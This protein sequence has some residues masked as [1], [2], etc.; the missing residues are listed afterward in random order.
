[1]I[2]MV[3]KVR[4]TL[5]LREG[6]LDIPPQKCITRD[7]APLSA[8]AVVYWK[9]FD[10]ELA[11]YAVADLVPAIQNLVLT[12][13]R[14]EIGKL[15]LDE[16]FSAREGINRALL[17]E[18]DVSTDAWGVKIT[19]VEVR[20]IIPNKEILSAMELQMAAER[21]KRADISKS[22]GQQLSAVNE[23]QGAADAARLTAEAAKVSV[24]LAAEAEKAR[25]TAEAEGAADALTALTKA[26]A[27][28]AVAA[29]Q[30]QVMREYIAAQRD[31]AASPNAKVLMFPGTDD[32]LLAKAGALFGSGGP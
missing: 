29:Q 23:A 11:T 13:L 15:T 27:G 25:L 3:D 19:R 31:V 6:V 26:C 30:L 17:E 16:T 2:P 28:D 22:E 21:K 18:L 14:S 8:D 10:P 32:G 9:I 24:V 20:D 7:N 1:M 12:Q 5:T 4:A